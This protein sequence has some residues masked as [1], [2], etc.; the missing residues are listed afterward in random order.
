MLDA[1]FKSDA[2][3]LTTE[4]STSCQ[5]FLVLVRRYVRLEAKKKIHT[6]NNADNGHNSQ[7]TITTTKRIGKRQECWQELMNWQVTSCDYSRWVNNT[8]PTTKKQSQSY[9][10]SK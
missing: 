4:S 7:F 1:G 8:K 10:L 6:V 3:A 5:V 2:Q 9:I